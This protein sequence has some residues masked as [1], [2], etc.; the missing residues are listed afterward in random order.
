VNKWKV[1]EYSC[2]WDGKSSVVSYRPMVAAILMHGKRAFPIQALIDSGSDSVMI[3]IETAAELG[4]AANTGTKV[5]VHGITG[6]IDTG[7]RREL[8]I[9]IPGLREFTTEVTFVPKLPVP[10]ILGQ[11]GFFDA[12]EVKFAKKESMFYLR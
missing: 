10:C 3:E 12:F 1:Y 4:I 8:T 7:F 2:D 6:S 11:R 5:Q 9:K